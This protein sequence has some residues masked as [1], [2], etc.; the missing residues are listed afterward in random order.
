MLMKSFR[1]P[2]H[3]AMVPSRSKL[4]Q[5][6]AIP[7]SNSRPFSGF[8]RSLS[9]SRK[10][11]F[12]GIASW[13]QQT[14]FLPWFLRAMASPICEPMQSPSGRTWPT[15]Q[16]RS[17][18]RIPS[19]ILSMRREDFTDEVAGAGSCIARLFLGGR[20]RRR[21]FEFR[22][23]VQHAIAARDRFINHETQLRRVFQD[24]GLGHEALDARAIL[25]QHSQAASLL[26]RAAQNANEN[27]RHTQIP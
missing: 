20:G 27:S 15:T 3:A 7:Q 14:T 22:D 6:V 21:A 16:K 25:L 12:F 4:A 13:F 10:A 23:D 9:G 8:C 26:L 24:H 18:S 17:L 1:L 11:S 2:M 19:R 5:S